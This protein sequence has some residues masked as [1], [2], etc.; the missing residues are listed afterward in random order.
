VA[1]VISD[2]HRLREEAGHPPATKTMELNAADWE[3]LFEAYN[4]RYNQRYR[5]LTSFS[6]K[7]THCKRWLEEIAPKR[8]AEASRP[9]DIPPRT[10]VVCPS[11]YP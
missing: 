7:L 10:Q 2:I 11:I 9:Q 3:E 8:D 1:L 6:N 5:L 4:L